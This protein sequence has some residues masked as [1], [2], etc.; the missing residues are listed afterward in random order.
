MTTRTLPLPIGQPEC[1]WHRIRCES[2]AGEWRSQLSQASVTAGDWRWIPSRRHR[3]R[4]ACRS[5]ACSSQPVTPQVGCTSPVRAQG[6]ANLQWWE[7]THSAAGFR[8]R[9]SPEMLSELSSENRAAARVATCRGPLTTQHTPMPVMRSRVPHRES[10]PSRGNVCVRSR[11]LTFLHNELPVVPGKTTAR[12]DESRDSPIKNREPSRRNAEQSAETLRRPPT[13]RCSEQQTTMCPRRT[14]APF[15]RT[16]RCSR[17]SRILTQDS[18]VSAHQSAEQAEGTL[19]HAADS[20]E[21]RERTGW[22]VEERRL[23][24]F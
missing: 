9:A 1:T 19:P 10:G 11:H 14:V 24:S 4:A 8:R 2:S 17:E 21:S 22:R 20:Q 15:T 13:T 16:S 7:A 18:T 12:R 5:T 6:D 23:P 3:A